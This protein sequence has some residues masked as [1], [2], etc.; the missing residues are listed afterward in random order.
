ME[1][2]SWSSDSTQEVATLITTEKFLVASD[3]A[4]D[5]TPGQGLLW[6]AAD[7]SDKAAGKILVKCSG[8]V[9]LDTTPPPTELKL[10]AYCRPPCDSSSSYRHSSSCPQSNHTSTTVT[11]NQ[12]L[13]TA[14]NA[15]EAHNNGCTLHPTIL[16]KQIRRYWDVQGPTNQR[17]LQ[18]CSQPTSHDP[19]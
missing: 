8:T 2:S 6:L 11:T 18:H 10:M 9:F 1:H 5:P 4:A 13:S 17:F 15:R 7:R 19:L 16:W 3:G 14:R 12:S